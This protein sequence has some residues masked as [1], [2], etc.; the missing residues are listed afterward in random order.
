M[1]SPIENASVSTEQSHLPGAPRDYRNGEHEGIDWYDHT[2]EAEISRDTPI[3]GQAEG[4]VVRA[5]H[6]FED[7]ESHEERNDDLELADDIGFTPEY[8][9][10]RLRGKQ[11][12][13]QYEDGVMMRF[14]HLEEIPEDI[15]VGEDVDEETVIGYVGNSGTSDALDGGDGGLHLHHDLLIYGELFW[16]PFTLDETAEVIHELWG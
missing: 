16:E 12:W 9:L 4:E 8:I 3:L 15:Q 2:S 14:A 5:D 1:N 7:Y 10:D 13:V 6:D 11:V